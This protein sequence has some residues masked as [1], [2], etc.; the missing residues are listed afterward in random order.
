MSSEKQQILTSF[1]QSLEKMESDDMMALVEKHLKDEDVEIFVQ[2]IETFYGITDDEELG[3][4]AQLMV[5]GYLAAKH[6]QSL[7]TTLN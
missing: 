6:E 2:H 3:M 5:T 4:L 1:F 7:K